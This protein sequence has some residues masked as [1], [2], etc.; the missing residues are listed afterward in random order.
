MSTEIHYPEFTGRDALLALIEHSLAAP[1]HEE[2]TDR[3]RHGLSDLIRNKTVFLPTCVFEPVE[4]HYAR[5]EIYSCAQ[6][7]TS[8]VAMTWAPGQGTPIHDHCGL[9]CVEGVWQGNLE[10]V[11]YELEQDSDERVR[12]S[13]HETIMAGTGSSGALIPPHEY[14]T[15]RNPNQDQIAVSL[16][17]Y[18]NAMNNCTSFEQLEGEW[19]RRVPKNLCLDAVQCD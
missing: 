19:Y 1:T 7:G 13:K 17:I 6:R 8:V 5:R 14:H 4:G 2:L 18:Q 12:F 16:H 10:I 3:M 9:W 11:R 15:I